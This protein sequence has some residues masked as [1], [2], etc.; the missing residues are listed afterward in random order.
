M[1][2]VLSESYM[3]ETHRGTWSRPQ[4]Q[5]NP[6]VD[7]FQYHA[8]VILEVIRA[9]VGLQLGLGLRLRGKY[10]LASTCILHYCN[11]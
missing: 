11:N 9:G 4:T 1:T 2:F 8:R 7:Y 5:T 3:A 6:S 10:N